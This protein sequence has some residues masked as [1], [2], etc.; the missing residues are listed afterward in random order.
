MDSADIEKYLKILGEELEKKGCTG[1]ILLAGGAI[2]LLVIKNRDTTKDIDAYFSVASSEIREAATKIARDHG[3]REDWLND[4]VKGFFY[5]TPPQS[6]WAEYPGLRVYLT[7]PEYIFA[8]KVAA[9]R[10]EDVPDIQALVKFLELKSPE[11]CLNIVQ[12]YIPT[13][14]LT[15]KMQYLIDDLFCDQIS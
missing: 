11:Q 3:L 10:V 5:G 8:M 1:E 9:G 7:D 13:H 2:M 12:K 6:L 14:L 4:G 15:A